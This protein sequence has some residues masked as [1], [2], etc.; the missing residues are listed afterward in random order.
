MLLF[1]HVLGQPQMAR[2]LPKERE[3]LAEST[4]VAQLAHEYIATTGIAYF[5]RL[6]WY[7]RYIHSC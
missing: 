2:V 6:A 5:K 4:N 7:H 1:L 3:T